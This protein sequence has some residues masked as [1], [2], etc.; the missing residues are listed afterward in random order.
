MAWCWVCRQRSEMPW[1]VAV[2]L[3]TVE[4]VSNLRRTGPSTAAAPCSHSA[5]PNV[6]A[7]GSSP[8]QHHRSIGDSQHVANGVDDGV[9][10]ETEVGSDIVGRP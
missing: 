9:D 3:S 4:L 6:I 10:G 8:S 5:R 2:S 1:Y 7:A